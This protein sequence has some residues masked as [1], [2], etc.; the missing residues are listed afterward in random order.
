MLNNHLRL[1]DVMCNLVWV[2]LRTCWGLFYVLLAM[3]LVNACTVCG[4]AQR[5]VFWSFWFLTNF[6]PAN[7]LTG[8]RLCGLQ[9]P[10]PILKSLRLLRPGL[11]F[12]PQQHLNS[13]SH[14][15]QNEGYVSQTGSNW[16]L[17]WFPHWKELLEE[18]GA[19][20]GCGCV[21]WPHREMPDVMWRVW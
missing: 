18:G 6:A 19:R 8:S 13:A 9:Q 3:D 7:G 14:F 4:Y 15:T 2:C 5:S 12:L 17:P 21:T 20:R 11:H 16:P 1:R 10:A